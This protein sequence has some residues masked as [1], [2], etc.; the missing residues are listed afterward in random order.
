MRIFTTFFEENLKKKLVNFYF[1]IS[2][3]FLIFFQHRLDSIPQTSDILEFVLPIGL[4]LLIN[5]DII[6]KRSLVTQSDG[7]TTLSIMTFSI[8]TFNIMTFSIMTFSIMTF[9]LMTISLMTFRVM[10]FSII[11]IHEMRHSAQLHSAYWQSI[12]MLSV[13]MLSL[14]LSVTYKPIMLSV[15][16]LNVVMPRVVAPLIATTNEYNPSLIFTHNIRKDCFQVKSN[17]LTVDNLVFHF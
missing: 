8:M 3:I 7:D 6:H 4:Q 9:S 16:M 13:I 10:T 15:I 17:L 2:R 5:I 1:I 12:I 11:M 14:V